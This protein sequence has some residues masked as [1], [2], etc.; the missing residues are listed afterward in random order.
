MKQ[1]RLADLSPFRPSAWGAWGCRPSTALRGRGRGGPCDPAGARTRDQL[2]RHGPALR[3]ADQR[4]A[5]GARNQGPPRRVRDRDQ[6]FAADGQ[7]HAGRHLHRRPARW[8][9]R[10]R[11]RL[12]RQLAAAPGHRP[13]R[14]VLPAPGRPQGPDRGDRR[15]DGGVGQ[16]G[17]GPAPRAHRA[18]PETIRRAHGVHPIAAVQSE[19]SLWTRDPE[20]E[21]LPACRE[22][23]IGFV[24][25]VPLEGGFL[26]GRFK[27]PEELEEG[28]FRRTGPRF[29]GENLEANL[30]L[31]AKV[32]E[33]A[34]GTG[35]TAAQLAIAWVLAQGERLVPIPGTKLTP[36]P[37]RERRRRRCRANERG[38]GPDR[39]RAAR[40]DG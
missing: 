16:G 4:A 20:A 1:R 3:A 29:T 22:L 23:G 37:G 33:I 38:P 9:R 34:A 17:Q 8:L 26:A 15:R 13:R 19:Y 36:L 28:D 11:A 2:H 10:A 21:I 14:P 6:V 7:R 40:G 18:G 5:R 12:D 30:K 25:Y 32:E 27:S 35:I 39:R 24:P 31:A